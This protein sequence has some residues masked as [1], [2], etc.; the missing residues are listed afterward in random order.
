MFGH[1]FTAAGSAVAI[2]QVTLADRTCA[3]PVLGS[4][5]TQAAGEAFERAAFG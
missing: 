5:G 1:L 3:A 4:K 2:D